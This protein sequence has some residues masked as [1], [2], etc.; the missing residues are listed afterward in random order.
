MEIIPKIIITPNTLYGKIKDIEIDYAN[1]QLSRMILNKYC[2]ET[3][4]HTKH[5][6]FMEHS[7][8][9]NNF[10]HFLLSIWPARSRYHFHS[11]RPFVH[12]PAAL[13]LFWKSD[14]DSQPH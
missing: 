11:P 13:P 1:F 5:H 7:L 2:K 4:F 10:K 14:P 8:R 9:D 6:L 12:M 3:I